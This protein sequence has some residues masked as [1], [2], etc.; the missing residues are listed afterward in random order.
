[1]ASRTLKAALA[2]TAIVTPLSGCSVWRY[3]RLAAVSEPKQYCEPEDDKA[4]M[5]LYRS[6]AE[7]AWA[8]H[9]GDC[10]PTCLAADYGWGF[11]EGFAEYVYA[12]GTGEPPAT[13]PRPY[14]QVDF[15]SPEGSLGVQS[16]FEGYRHGARVARDGGYRRCA[17]LRVSASLADCGP[18]GRP[19]RDG[20]LLPDA[21]HGPRL[22]PV[23]VDGP[24][25]PAPSPT[26]VL[27]PLPEAAEPAQLPSPAEPAPPTD[28]PEADR[29]DNGAAQPAFDE[30]DLGDRLGWPLLATPR[31][32]LPETA[33]AARAADRS[34]IFPIVR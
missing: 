8:E 19:N 14:W 7:R 12:G 17:T 24:V 6:W 32:V 18:C 30:A 33:A 20:T 9:A 10:P 1:M 34:A 3:A 29:R 31:S 22:V 13:P 26:E 5:A 25:S 23:E 27:V 11:R 28:E 4:S 21:G 16:W 15:R 2:L